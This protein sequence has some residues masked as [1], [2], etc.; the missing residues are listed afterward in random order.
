MKRPWYALVLC[1]LLALPS[2]ARA[3]EVGILAVRAEGSLGADVESSIVD[4]VA[5]VLTASGALVWRPEAIEQE[6][7]R[8][9]IPCADETCARDIFTTLG[10]DELVEIVV[11]VATD[12]S[13]REVVVSLIPPSGEPVTAA[14]P[15]S[16][17]DPADAAREATAAARERARG[18]RGQVEVRIEG[19]PRFA[20]VVIDGQAVGMLPFDGM[21][22]EG[23]HELVVSHQGYRPHSE[24][25]EVRAGMDPLTVRLV[26]V[27]SG[28]EWA[29]PTGIAALVAGLGLVAVPIAGELT[30]GCTSRV[31][32]EC[33]RATDLDL[34][35]ALGWGIAGGVLTVAGI[36]LVIVGATSGGGGE[37]VRARIGAGSLALEGTFR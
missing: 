33:E 2:A 29:I 27:A 12:G 8:G 4:A 25:I 5:V 32:G 28:A 19:E 23:P 9:R 34:G 36:V 3:D 15:V 1:L 17:G 24:R 11:R 13:V 35:A 7:Q 31:A 10:F 16:N 26:P 30:T 22:D 6:R 14:R 20:S 37:Q 21:L 18:Q